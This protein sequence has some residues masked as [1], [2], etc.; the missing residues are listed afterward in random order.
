VSTSSLWP[1][2]GRMV[3]V[4]IAVSATD[5]V[6]T[7]PACGVAG[8]TSNEGQSADWQIVGAAIV[9]LRA[10]REGNGPGRV[11]TITVRCTEASGNSSSANT[12]VTV[13]HD[14]GK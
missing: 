12:V 10:T 2:N 1:P 5:R 14:Q 3:P 13:P 6:D 4:T 9:N 11:Y 8:V 7:A